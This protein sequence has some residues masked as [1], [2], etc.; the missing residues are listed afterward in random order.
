MCRQQCKMSG[1]HAE[2][3]GKIAGPSRFSV[4]VLRPIEPGFY[5][6]TNAIYVFTKRHSFVMISMIELGWAN[7]YA[8]QFFC[9]GVECRAT[10]F[11]EAMALPRHTKKPGTA[12]VRRRGTSVASGPEQECVAE[13]PE[14][15]TRRFLR[16]LW[17]KCAAHVVWNNPGG[18]VR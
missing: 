6:I 12:F 15:C 17:T 11:P 4:I 2:N 5:W 14:N 9:V 18:C 13:S 16:E 10:L 3:P 7:R 8:I 1:H